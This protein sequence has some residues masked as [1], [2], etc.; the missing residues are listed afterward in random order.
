LASEG[1]DGGVAAGEAAGPSSPLLPATHARLS[2]AGLRPT[3]PGERFGL[4]TWDGPSH[5]HLRSADIGL[6]SSTSP[7][8]WSYS[9]WRSGVTSFGLLGRLAITLACLL[10][11]YYWWQFVG[12]LVLLPVLIWVLVGAPL[13]VRDTWKRERVLRQDERPD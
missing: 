11:A 6:P 2:L 10:P 9:R 7:L 12:P 3:P 5:D 13:V 4:P 1:A 8:T